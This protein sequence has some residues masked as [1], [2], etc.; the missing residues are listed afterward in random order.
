MA[1]Y[2]KMPNNPKLD[3]DEA[4]NRIIEA[5]LRD[6]PDSSLHSAILGAAAVNSMLDSGDMYKVHDYDPEAFSKN[7]E[8]HGQ[9]SQNSHKSGKQNKNKNKKRAFKPRK[10]I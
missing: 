2:K 1:T 4:I 8:K 5:Y 6:N 9:S 3:A 10:D 7:L